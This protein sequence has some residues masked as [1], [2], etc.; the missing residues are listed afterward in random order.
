MEFPKLGDMVLILDDFRDSIGIVVAVPRLVP[1]R[2]G[3]L[4]ET[5]E[6]NYYHPMEVDPIQAP[7]TPYTRTT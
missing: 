5:G 7:D 3:V 6:I 4:I 2:I 1:E